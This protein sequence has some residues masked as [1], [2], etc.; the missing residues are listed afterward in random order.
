M[1]NVLT[2]PNCRALLQVES[3]LSRTFCAYCGAQV[4]LDAKFD[5]YA[6]RVN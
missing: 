5:G 6:V 1:P 3:G 4:Q 2:C